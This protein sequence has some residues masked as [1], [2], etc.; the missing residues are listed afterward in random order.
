MQKGNKSFRV[1]KKINKSLY[2]H[3]YEI[4]PALTH[5]LFFIG[6]KCSS[7]KKKKKRDTTK[8]RMD[9]VDSEQ[10]TLIGVHSGTFYY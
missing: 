5:M 3:P 4:F 7:K 6:A 9:S 2:K 8:C 10:S 1:A